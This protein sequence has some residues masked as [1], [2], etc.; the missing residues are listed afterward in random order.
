M[1]ILTSFTNTAGSPRARRQTWLRTMEL[2]RETLP[3]I[4]SSRGPSCGLAH[5][6]RVANGCD[7]QRADEKQRGREGQ[8]RSTWDIA[9]DASHWF[10]P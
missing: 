4:E 10:H 9:V 2:N 8:A 6:T 5:R 1:T 7:L 3:R